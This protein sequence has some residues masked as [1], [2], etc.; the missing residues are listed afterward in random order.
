[1][2]INGWLLK[3]TLTLLAFVKHGGMAKINGKLYYRAMKL[4]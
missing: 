1:M 4:K 3:K 2:N